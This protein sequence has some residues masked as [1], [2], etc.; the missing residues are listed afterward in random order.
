MQ[1]NNQLASISSI[2]MNVADFLLCNALPFDCFL[3]YSDW[4]C[5]LLFFSLKQ[6]KNKQ[7]NTFVPKKRIIRWNIIFSVNFFLR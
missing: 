3:Y 1:Q 7:T 5:S 6:T 4:E 2:T